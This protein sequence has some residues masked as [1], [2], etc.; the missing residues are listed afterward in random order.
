MKNK[1]LYGG[2]LLLGVVGLYMW[3]KKSTSVSDT[4]TESELN[5]KINK[6]AKEQYAKIKNNAGVRS[7]S[8]IIDG[9]KTL[10]ERVKKNGF[11]SKK[12]IDKF[13]SLVI[14]MEDKNNPLTALESL[15]L[16]KY[17]E[18]KK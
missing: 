4:Y 9:L 14:R 7:E 16:D 3:N 8:Q 15:S 12:D 6:L 2:L 1:I 5:D 17:I 18:V 10:T 11:T 13:L